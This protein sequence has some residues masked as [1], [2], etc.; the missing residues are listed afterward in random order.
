MIVIDCC[1]Y[2]QYQQLN[3]AVEEQHLYIYILY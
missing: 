1:H 3:E 2:L